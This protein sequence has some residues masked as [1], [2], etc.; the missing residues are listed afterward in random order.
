MSNV[1]KALDSFQKD[2]NVAGY[3]TGNGTVGAPLTRQDLEPDIVKLTDHM[4]PLRE[5]IKRVQGQG[6]AHAWNQRT[7]L[8]RVG[9]NPMNLGYADGGL[10]TQSDQNYVQKTAAYKWLGVTKVITGPMIAVSRSYINLE[11][12]TI[13]V[14]LREVIQG[15]EWMFLKGDSSVVSTDFDGLDVQIVTNVLSQNGIT[16]TNMD[17]IDT[18]IKKIRNQGGK[19]G[20]VL[21]SYGMQAI[22]SRILAPAT[23]YIANNGTTVTAGIFA[24]SYQSPVGVLPIA[25]DFFVNPTSPFAYNTTSSS[26]NDGAP[27]ST[28]YV[29]DPTQIDWVQLMPVARVDLAK[30]AD[31]VRFF[32]NEYGVLALK[33]EVWQGK[34]TNVS[35]PAS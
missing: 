1:E 2:I 31:T 12:E 7:T 9:S 19:P 11:A 29:L 22:I 26:S 6:L 25:G 23:M 21:C 30:I 35:D 4:T 24:T 10:P 20:M 27:E 13:E 33:A 28:I 17:N 3:A 15:E 18:I 32:I 5:E 14:G 34:L 16:L 8:G